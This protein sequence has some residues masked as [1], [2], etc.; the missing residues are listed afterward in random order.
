MSRGCNFRPFWCHKNS[1]KNQREVY[2]EGHSKGCEKH[3]T[4]FFVVVDL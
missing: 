4:F 2:V 3:G 1:G